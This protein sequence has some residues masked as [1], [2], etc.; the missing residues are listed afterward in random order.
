MKFDGRIE[1]FESYLQSLFGPG[2]SY[3][4]KE[5]GYLL[6]NLRPKRKINPSKLNTAKLQAIDNQFNADS[7]Y[8]VEPKVR[9]SFNSVFF[10]L[11]K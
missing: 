9:A 3:H 8:K 5:I 4:H 1:G 6:E 10:V 11:S 2:G 7:R